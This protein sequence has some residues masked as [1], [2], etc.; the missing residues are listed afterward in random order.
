MNSKKLCK[1]LNIKKG[2]T[3]QKSVNLIVIVYGF[4]FIKVGNMNILIQLLPT[5]T[6]LL[7]PYFILFSL[8]S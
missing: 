8:L 4:N 6:L 2:N 5:N 3:R 1:R 7:A